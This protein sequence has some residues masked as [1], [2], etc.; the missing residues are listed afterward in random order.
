MGDLIFWCVVVYG[1]CMALHV[2]YPMY[3]EWN[4]GQRYR[5]K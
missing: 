2:L 1:V 4:I 5:T 3:I